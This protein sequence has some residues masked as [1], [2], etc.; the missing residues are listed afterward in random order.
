M[1]SC[2]S[3]TARSHARH[4]VLHEHGGYCYSLG[5]ADS[6]NRIYRA[7]NLPMILTSAFALNS[8]SVTVGR[9]LLYLGS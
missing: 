2:W 6:R 7:S 4:G 3:G 1:I 9:T 8:P 5:Y